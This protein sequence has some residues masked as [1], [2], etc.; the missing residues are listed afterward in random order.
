MAS[1][2]TLVKRQHEKTTYTVEQFQEFY[3]C[4]QDPIHFITKYVKIKHPKRGSVNFEMY[5]FQK[6][7]VNVMV[8]NTLSIFMLPRQVGKSTTVVSF[9]L[10]YASFHKDKTILIVSNKNSSA[11]EMIHKIKII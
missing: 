6:D 4:S 2:N 11:Q 3:K 8:D 7:M 9:L 10:W 5:D 1:K